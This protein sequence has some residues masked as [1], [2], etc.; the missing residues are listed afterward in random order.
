MS[1]CVYWRCRADGAV[2]IGDGDGVAAYVCERHLQN[3]AE[4]DDGTILFRSVEEA[5]AAQ[6]KWE[7]PA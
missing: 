7:E 3:T 5:R 2:W 4:T 1:G 6:Q